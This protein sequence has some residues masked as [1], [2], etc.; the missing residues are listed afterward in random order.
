MPHVIYHMKKIE[1]HDEC[2]KLV[3][4][5][6][7]SC[8]S[9]VQKLNKNSIEFSLSTWTWSVIKS[10]QAKSLYKVQ[11]L[12]TLHSLGEGVSESQGVLVEEA[13]LASGVKVSCPPPVV[14]SE[15][16][17]TSLSGA[18]QVSRSQAITIIQF[19]YFFIAAV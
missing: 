12:C 17:I 1:S 10:S 6:C 5:P 18:C 8:I 11:A 16:Y 2:G 19:F 7:S 14:I 15:S 3:H 4:R 9:S 13:S